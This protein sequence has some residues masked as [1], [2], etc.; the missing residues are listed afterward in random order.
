MIASNIDRETHPLARRARRSWS[1]LLAFGLMAAGL[2]ATA[3]ELAPSKAAA[4]APQGAF[5]GEAYGTFAT[6]VVGP[7]ATTLGRSAY[8]PCPCQGT[9]G[10]TK[11]NNVTALSAGTL[12]KVLR[13]DAVTSTVFARKTGTA[14]EV[15]NTSTIT[16][17]NLLNGLITA[18]TV[19]SVASTTATATATSSNAAGST[20]VNLSINGRR[21][22][23]DPAPNSRVELPGIGTV[24]LNKR[25]VS[26]NGQ[27]V[28]TILVEGLTVEVKTAN[29]FGL[30]VGARIVVAHAVSGFSR[31]PVQNFVGGQ[32][33]A[34]AA[35]AAIGTVIQNQIGKAAL[36]TIG[37]EGTGGKTLGN[38][39]QALAVGKVLRT[40][41]GVTT[42]F[43]GPDTG[44]G[45]IARTTA[46]VENASLLGGLISFAAI[47]ASAEDRFNGGLH[48]RSAAGTQILGLRVLGLPVSASVAPNTRINLPA[49]GY[50]IVN[51]RKF[52]A[53]AANGLTQVN[54][55]RIVVN[56][57][58]TLGLPVGSE[59]VVA[60]AEANARR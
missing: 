14:A 48:V 51:E 11:Q 47:T 31:T 18:T 29:S 46:R 41:T 55:L 39:I 30:P 3:A 20:F 40:G 52:P 26:G 44:G 38:N 9:S 37:C 57:A 25:V 50:V 32:A 8:L 1:R 6:G 49:L 13:A 10:Q 12:G 5:R 27:P 59:I 22:A 24:V 45:T 7:I 17:L 4:A 35:N 15:T 34:A 54:G 42:A 43:G 16:G 2:A 23:A 21:I 28:Q 58:N 36:V 56:T 19:K 33:Y 60:H 53:P